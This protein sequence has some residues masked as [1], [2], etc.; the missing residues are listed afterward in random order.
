MCVCVY[1]Q[2]G[3]LYIKNDENIITDKNMRR[4]LN[5]TLSSRQAMTSSAWCVLII[6]VPE[7][8]MSEWISE[9]WW[10]RIYTFRFNSFLLIFC[11]KKYSLFLTYVTHLYVKIDEDCW[12]IPEWVVHETFAKSSSRNTFDETTILLLEINII[13]CAIYI[14]WWNEHRHRI[15]ELKIDN[16]AKLFGKPL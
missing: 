10:W 14:Y 6:H 5:K 2:N 13:L 8:R 11:W 12:Y 7:K 1:E 3:N 9:C 16:E 15:N 4:A